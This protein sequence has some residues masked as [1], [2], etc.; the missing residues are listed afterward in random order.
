MQTRYRLLAIDADGTLVNSRQ[1]V[2][3]AN[4]RALGRARDAG[5][6]VALCTGR[7]LTETLSLLDDLAGLID[8]AVCV[9]GALVSDPRTRRTI[10]RVTLDPRLAREVC[11]LLGSEGFP[12]LVILDRDEWPVDAYLLPGW[13]NRDHFE[14]WVAQGPCATL[15][16]DAYPG[17][18][19]A[20]LRLMGVGPLE[21]IVEL[22]QWLLGRFGAD[23]LTVQNIFAPNYGLHVLEIFAPG[24]NKWTGMQVIMQD[25]QLSGWQVV[26]IGDDVNDLEMVQQAGLGVAMANAIDS[27]KAAAGVH[28]ASHDEDGV[29]DFIDRLLDGTLER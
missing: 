1:E 4:R 24:L 26:A 13:R 29:A 25:W 23:R 11:D 21:V 14:Q 6:R 3:A 8:V 20:P 18:V 5:L 9:S 17:E 22:Q 2:S 12:A 28:T 10:H 27:I 19:P 16:V 7:I 15:Q